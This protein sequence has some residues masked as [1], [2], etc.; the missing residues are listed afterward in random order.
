LGEKKMNETPDRD[1]WLRSSMLGVKASILNAQDDLTGPLR[2]CEQA[3]E[4][5]ADPSAYLATD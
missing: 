2:R 3:S 1:G 5:I 4:G